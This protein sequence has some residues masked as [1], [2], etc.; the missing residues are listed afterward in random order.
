MDFIRRHI[1]DVIEK[2]DGSFKGV[3]L[4]GARQTGKSTL[5]RAL[6]PEKDTLPST[7]H[8]LKSR[9]TGTRTSS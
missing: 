2:A 8:S 4:T 5:L 3:L 1:S 6:F 9:Q 7:I